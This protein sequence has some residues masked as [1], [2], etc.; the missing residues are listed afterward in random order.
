MEG[1]GRG[2]EGGRGGRESFRTVHTEDTFYSEGDRD[3][4]VETDRDDMRPD[5]SNDV[6]NHD[7]DG[8]DVESPRPGSSD[9][10]NGSRSGNRYVTM[11][12]TS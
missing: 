6:H 2:R 11:D 5:D 7:R 1:G 9:S 3:H 4:A 8:D 10:R 12:R